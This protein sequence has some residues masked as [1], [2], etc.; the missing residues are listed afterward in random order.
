M[1]KQHGFKVLWQGALVALLLPLYSLNAA[2]VDEGGTGN[3][4]FANSNI[5]SLDI[6][7]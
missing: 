1:K 7:P 4:G 6:H 2:A 3:A 5:F